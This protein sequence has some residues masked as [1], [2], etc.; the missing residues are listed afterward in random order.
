MRVNEALKKD[1][2][3]AIVDKADDE[4]DAL[5]CRLSKPKVSVMLV[6]PDS[7]RRKVAD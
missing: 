3:S 1:N 6:T 2:D 7:M 4:S 5:D